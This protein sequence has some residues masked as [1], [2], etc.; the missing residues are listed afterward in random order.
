ML[1]A[2]VNEH[3]TAHCKASH[4]SLSNIS[5]PNNVSIMLIDVIASLKEPEIVL[6]LAKKVQ[7]VIYTTIFN[8]RHLQASALQKLSL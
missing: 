4:L 2:E 1:N 3:L 8:L 6:C 5:S 7:T